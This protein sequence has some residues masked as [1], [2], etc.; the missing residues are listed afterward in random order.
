MFSSKFILIA[1]LALAAYV[2]TKR[3]RP[4][5]KVISGTKVVKM[6]TRHDASGAW[7]KDLPVPTNL[8]GTHPYGWA[9]CPAGAYLH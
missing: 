8:Q 3:T 6:P 7:K 9:G 2:Y 1:S 4:P 5:E